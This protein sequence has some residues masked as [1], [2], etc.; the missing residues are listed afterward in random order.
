MSRTCPDTG[1]TVVYLN[2]L[3][4]EHKAD[5]KSG[6]YAPENRTSVNDTPKEK[7]YNCSDCDYCYSNETMRA[8]IHICINYGSDH[9]GQP[10]DWLGL[11]DDD[12]ECVVINGNDY[13]ELQD[14]RI[15]S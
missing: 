5:C 14:Q 1:T 4:C 2:C 12:M 15:Q 11:A 3:E 8:G 10:V 9:F 7:I 13:S 6:D